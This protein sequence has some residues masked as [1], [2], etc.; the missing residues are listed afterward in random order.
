MIGRKNPHQEFRLFLIGSEFFR[1]PGGIQYVNR[2]L[3]RAFESFGR[4]IPTALEVLSLND[5]PEAGADRLPAGARWHACERRRATAVQTMT[6]RASRAQP[7]VALF[8]HVSLLALAAI[9]RILSPR[10]RIALLGHGIEVWKPLDLLLR[11]EVARAHAVVVPSR[12]TRDKIIE[13]NGAR[14]EQVSVIAHGLSAEWTGANAGLPPAQRSGRV[15]LSVTRLVQ[16]DAQKGVDVVLRAMPRI[17]ER[18]PEAR[19][20][21]VG[22][23]NDRPRLESLAA[24]LGVQDRVEFRGKLQ[25]EELR[26][27][28]READVF[29]LPS[30]T[31][32]FG[33][34]FAE[35]MWHGLPVV[36]ARAAGTLDVVEDGVTGILVPPDEPAQLSSAVSG[37]LLLPEERA[38]LAAAGRARVEREFL[39][40]HFAERWH[41]WLVS[42]AA[43]EAY[44]ARHAQ[45][46]PLRQRELR[47]PAAT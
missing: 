30:Q 44:L 2:E 47:D 14:P 40:A 24:T 12:Y 38:R 42:V 39:S 36:A 9:V 13:C 5:L 10:T 1:E 41:R 8:T 19:Y 33:I 23:G 29:V 4:K 45:A 32:G 26:C 22:D 37:L 35:A 16:S 46:F 17:L 27:S 18:C 15:L 31:E 11:A 34:V 28:Y 20:V 43:E 25:D 6:R 7:H 3:L 21:V